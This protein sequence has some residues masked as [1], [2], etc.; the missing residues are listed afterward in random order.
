MKQVKWAFIGLG[1]PGVE[2]RLSRHNMGFLVVD[3]FAQK[4]GL[5]WSKGFEG[6]WAFGE[7]K[8][9]EILLFKPL[10]FMNLSGK[11]IGKL[12]NQV[13]IP[14]EKLLVIHDDLDLPFGKLRLKRGGGDGGHKGVK[15]II[16]TIGPDF[17]RLKIGIGRP[18]KKEEVVQ[19]VLS[20][21]S[22]EELKKLPHLM[23]KVHALLLTLIEEGL[24]PTMNLFNREAPLT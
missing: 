16:E 19:Y 10:T 24:E 20:P 4:Y 14:K 9:K 23:E 3:G 22:E 12:L 7:I 13:P 17:P 8:A 2:Y 21:F 11:A 18:E 15:S 6:E 5:H 1:N